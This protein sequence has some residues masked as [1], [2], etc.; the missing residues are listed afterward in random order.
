MAVAVGAESEARVTRSH[1][2][3][4]VSWG[5]LRKDENLP[6]DLGCLDFWVFSNRYRM[7]LSKK[8]YLRSLF[9]SLSV[10]ASLRGRREGDGGST[11]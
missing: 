7:I 8:R 1:R 4:V 3:V 6:V 11:I 2:G 10:H 5:R 9:C